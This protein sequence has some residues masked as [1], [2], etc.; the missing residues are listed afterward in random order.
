MAADA[1]HGREL[2]KAQCGLCHQG[3]AGDGD[4]GQG[5]SLQGVIG[6]KIGGDTSFPYSPP[7]SEAK[8]AWTESAVD[9]FLK[10]PQKVFPGTA[11]PVQVDQAAERADI[12][13]YLAALKP[14][15]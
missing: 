13:A 1:A 15:P 3:A 2:F 9:A 14:A 6:R 8:A 5:P 7:L 4:G 11:M 12:V 10:D